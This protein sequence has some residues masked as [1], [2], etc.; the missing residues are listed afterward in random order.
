MS[1]TL[2]GIRISFRRHRASAL[3]TRLLPHRLFCALNAT[4]ALALSSPSF[5]LAA[6]QKKVTY[7]DDILPIFRDNCLKCHNPDK[8]KGD[9]DLTV[10]DAD[11]SEPA[12]R[13]EFPEVSISRKDGIVRA[14]GS[15]NGG[16]EKVRVQ[17]TSGTIRLRRGPAAQK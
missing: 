16:G 5:A 2:Q 10:T 14:T 4:L 3:S 6:D 9:L 17:T 11:P 12:V 15:V 7:E 8:L 13:S 1:P